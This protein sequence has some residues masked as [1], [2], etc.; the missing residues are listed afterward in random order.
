MSLLREM[1]KFEWNNRFEAAFDE[2]K[3]K[4]TTVLILSLPME[5]GEFVIYSDASSQ[6]IGCVLMQ[7]GKVIAYASKQLKHYEKNYPPMT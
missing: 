3:H 7:D 2:L 4:L 6:G 5:R 1:T